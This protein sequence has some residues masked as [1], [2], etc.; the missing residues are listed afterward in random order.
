MIFTSAREYIDSCSSNRA[1][2]T[3]I[4]NVI[5]A[6][7]AQSATAAAGDDIQ[8]YWL[9]DGQTQIKTIYRGA[10]NISRAILQF[11]RLKNYYESKLVGRTTILVDSKNFRGA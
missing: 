1:R 3:A 9:N 7:I 2:I 5:A 8:E 6:L 10:S 11:E 4:D